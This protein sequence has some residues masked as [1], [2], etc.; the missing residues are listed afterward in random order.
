MQK[1]RAQGSPE[2][3]AR[4]ILEHDERILGL[5]MS[6]PIRLLAL[7]LAFEGLS[8]HTLETPCAEP[9]EEE[10]Q[11]H[12]DD[13]YPLAEEW[14]A[15]FGG[16]AIGGSPFDLLTHL[17]ACGTL[18]S[19]LETERCAAAEKC[20]RE[21]LGRASRLFDALVE[22]ER[23]EEFADALS[24]PNVFEGLLREFGIA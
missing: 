8:S 23:S 14:D 19:I 13:W 4:N 7:Q 16:I 18:E 12:E 22:N 2:D 17:D 3:L 24:D 6:T 10:L 11:D 9:E 21:T 20:T 1:T 15:G 5:I